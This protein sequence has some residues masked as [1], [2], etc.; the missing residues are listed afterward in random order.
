MFERADVVYVYDG[1]YDGLLCCVFECYSRKETPAGV[2]PEDEA[3]LSLYERRYVETDGAKAA[4]VEN[5]LAKA[6]SRDAAETGRLFYLSCCP[7]KGITFL[8]FAQICIQYGTKVRL[9]LTD[10]TVKKVRDSVAH[11]T[12]EA[13]QLKGFVRFSVNGNA[14]SSVIEPKNFVLPLLRDYFC[15][16]YRNESFLI[17]DKTH[18]A[19]LV[20]SGGRS[21][22]V[23]IENFEEPEAEDGETRFREL[24]RLFYNTVAIAERENP[25]CRMSHMQKR[26]WAHM[27]EMRQEP[28]RGRA[29]IAGEINALPE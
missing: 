24:W 18:G 12:R 5:G 4:R 3:Q 28:G 16:R 26:Y 27:T 19:A 7:D 8:L 6:A 22:I 20:Y 15:N 17:Y 23:P 1:S 14:M 2:V 9:M 11:L 13:H 25:R 21:D 10:E 29:A